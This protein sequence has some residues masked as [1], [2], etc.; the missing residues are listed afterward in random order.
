MTARRTTTCVACRHFSPHPHFLRLGKEVLLDRGGQRRMARTAN[1]ALGDQQVEQLTGL[2][3][4]AVQ[5]VVGAEGARADVG[6][7]QPGAAG[8]QPPE[9]GHWGTCMRW[10]SSCRNRRVSPQ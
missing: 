2:A 3:V 6:V 7:G 5:T 8:P 4:T 9:G 1:N 10:P